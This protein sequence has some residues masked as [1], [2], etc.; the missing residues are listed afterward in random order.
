MHNTGINSVVS[1]NHMQTIIPDTEN[2]IRERF[3]KRNFNL[4]RMGKG[5][6]TPTTPQINIK[7]ASS[8]M[9]L[10][11]PISCCMLPMLVTLTS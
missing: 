3:V 9:I 8:R 2:S 11:S 5:I 1:D 6:A 7:V 4:K 10:I